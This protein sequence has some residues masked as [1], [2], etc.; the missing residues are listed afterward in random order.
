MFVKPLKFSDRQ[1]CTFFVHFGTDRLTKIAILQINHPWKGQNYILCLAANF[2]NWALSKKTIK[3]LTDVRK[4]FWE[5]SEF[6]LTLLQTSDIY[7][8]EKQKSSLSLRGILTL[9]AYLLSSV[10]E[11]PEIL[12]N[13][14]V[15]CWLRSFLKTLLIIFHSLT[16]MKILSIYLI[17][18]WLI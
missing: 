7:C 11:R 6:N 8:I 17:Y 3:F 13:K 14:L 5:V 9:F 1:K 18:I 4:K 2:D 10:Q 12:F 16:F 15:C